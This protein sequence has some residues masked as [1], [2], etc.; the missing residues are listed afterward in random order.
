MQTGGCEREGSFGKPTH[1]FKEVSNLAHTRRA[2]GCERRISRSS[3]GDDLNAA[4]IEII[5]FFR[6]AK[7][8]SRWRYFVHC[9]SCTSYQN[10]MFR[11]SSTF[12]NLI[13]VIRSTASSL[14]SSPYTDV[15]IVI[16]TN[17]GF[18]LN[19]IS[20]SVPQS[21]LYSDEWEIL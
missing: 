21:P 17:C 6:Y 9:S 10:Y 12:V 13:H 4:R 16:R 11:T 1:F 19:D 3:V 2:I 7:A 5:D 14:L 20:I 8:R 18:V 15:G